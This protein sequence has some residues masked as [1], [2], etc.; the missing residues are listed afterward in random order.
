MWNTVAKTPKKLLGK[1]L[2]RS[3]I[4]RDSGTIS[5]LR[6]IGFQKINPLIALFL[7][8]LAQKIE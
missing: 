8:H 3:D 4:Y 7:A 2:D 5:P 6:P 1:T